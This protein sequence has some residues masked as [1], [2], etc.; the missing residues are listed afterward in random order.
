MSAS[1]DRC[2]KA[3][4]MNLRLVLKGNYLL[5]GK[6]ITGVTELPEQKVKLQENIPKLKKKTRKTSRKQVNISIHLSV[7]ICIFRWRGSQ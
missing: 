1:I 7:S 4:K 3:F 2:S 5:A 6:L